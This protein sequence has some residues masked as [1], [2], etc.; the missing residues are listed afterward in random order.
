MALVVTR[1]ACEIAQYGSF[2]V[3]AAARN[4]QIS[5]DIE[6]QADYILIEMLHCS[7]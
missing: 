3:F 7:N 5:I 4:S 2:K 6:S 1:P